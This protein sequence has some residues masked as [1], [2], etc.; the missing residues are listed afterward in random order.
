MI[1]FKLGMTV[2]LWIPLY[3]YAHA[4]FDDLDARSHNRSAKA[5][6]QHCML[7][8]TKQ[9]ISIKLAT[10]V[11]LLFFYVPFTLQTFIWLV[12]LG[13]V[14]VFLFVSLLNV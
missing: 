12:Q 3:I 14:W 13:F 6:N 1:T 9:A 2:D 11:G 10:T 7:S 8:A 5:K 4:C